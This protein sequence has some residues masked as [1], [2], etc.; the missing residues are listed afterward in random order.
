MVDVLYSWL[1]SNCSRCGQLGH[2]ASRCLLLQT[3]KSCRAASTTVPHVFEKSMVDAIVIAAATDPKALTVT[4]MGE[5]TMEELESASNMA[6]VQTS[7]P[8]STTTKAVIP[9]AIGTN[10]TNSNTIHSRERACITINNRS[11][12]APSKEVVTPKQVS[13]P[14]IQVEHSIPRSPSNLSLSN[15]RFPSFLE[16][17]EE[18]ADSDNEPE[19]MDFLTPSGKRILRERPVKPSAKVKEMQWQLVGSG[20]GNRGRGNRGDRG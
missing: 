17:E 11:E 15:N 12:L 10:L 4:V 7:V 19:Q 9:V 2:K 14:T 5:A 16:D 20:R 3:D 6:S 8:I 13:P 1:P 18:P